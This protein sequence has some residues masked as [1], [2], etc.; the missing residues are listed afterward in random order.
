MIHHPSPQTI[1]V[2]SDSSAT[3]A[4]AVAPVPQRAAIAILG[5]MIFLIVALLAVLVQT[6]WGTPASATEPP[7]VESENLAGR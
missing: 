6:T 5:S 7:T 2:P 1:T 4:T 3:P